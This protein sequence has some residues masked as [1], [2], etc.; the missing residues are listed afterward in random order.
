MPDR[1]VPY[2]STLN[3]EYYNQLITSRTLREFTL[4]YYLQHRQELE[5]YTLDEYIE[6]F[7]VDDTKLAQ[8]RKLGESLGV[9]FNEDDYRLSKKHI[10]AYIKAEIARSVWDDAG[11][12]PVYNATSNQSFIEALNL[13]D[14]AQALAGNYQAF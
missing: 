13:V 2:D 5:A 9:A 10:K 6:R 8:V 7:R 1:F 14:E 3:T 12:Y 11:F 4:T